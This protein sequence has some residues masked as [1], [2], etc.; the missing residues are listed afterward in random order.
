MN[1]NVNVNV[2]AVMVAESDV[3][4]SVMSSE[5]R[6]TRWDVMKEWNVA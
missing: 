6:M 1:V 3:I 2:S 5:A 4:D